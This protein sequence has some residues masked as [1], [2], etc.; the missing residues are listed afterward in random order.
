MAFKGKFD[1]VGN[2]SEGL[3]LVR[4]GG[5]YFYINK[6]GER[7]FEGE[8]DDAF[9]FSEGVAW[10]KKDGKWFYIDIRGRRVFG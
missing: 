1:D 2:F 5:Q 7:A 10:V 6:K 9:N 8:F 4:K 3:A